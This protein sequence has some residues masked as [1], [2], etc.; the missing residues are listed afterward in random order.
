MDSVCPVVRL[1]LPGSVSG[2][3]ITSKETGTRTQSVQFSQHSLRH[4][5]GLSFGLARPVGELPDYVG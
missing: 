3:P 4:F 1:E 5:C 2:R